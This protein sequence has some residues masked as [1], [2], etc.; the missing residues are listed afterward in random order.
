MNGWARAFCRRCL[1]A[2]CLSAASI[3]PAAAQTALT[4]QEERLLAILPAGLKGLGDDILRAPDPAAQEGLIRTLVDRAAASEVPLP[5]GPFL[6]SLADAQRCPENSAGWTRPHTAPCVAQ[7]A[8]LL[9]R[10]GDT[11]LRQALERWAASHPDAGVADH[12]LRALERANAAHLTAL[13]GKRIDLARAAGDHAALGTLGRAQERVGS[14]LP[15][16]WWQP[17]P[18]F[19][20]APPAKRIRVVA[21]GDFGTGSASQQAVAA[22]LRAYHRTH[23]FDFGITLGDNYQDDGPHGPTDPRWRTY[24]TSL[25]S[26]LGIPFY[27]SLGNHDWGNPDGPAASMVFARQDPA[28]RLPGLYYTYTAGPVQFFVVNTPLLSEAQ[29]Q[30]LRAE[31]AAST[32]RWRVVYGHYQMYSVLRG[33]NQQLITHLLPVLQEFKVHM[34]LCGHEHIFQHLKPVGG[35]EFFVSG[36]A[37]G[38]GRVARQ[39]GYDRVQFMAEQEQ[40]F[41]VLEADADTLTVR[42]VGAAGQTVYETTLR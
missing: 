8:S 30:W 17:P 23:P 33:D 37:G 42:F 34:Y 1:A 32:A 40:G 25:Y 9:A 14:R 2:F 21:L 36:A 11:Y 10:T 38:S 4:A 13:L 24:W 20:A 3:A 41:T 27:A 22:T 16:F 39:Q 26:S 6:V 35:V 31:L 7:V 15:L 29:L 18:R 12:A 28:L 5:V 19:V